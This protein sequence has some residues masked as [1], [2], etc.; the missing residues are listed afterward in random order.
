MLDFLHCPL[1]GPHRFRAV[2]E[3]ALAMA[4]LASAGRAGVDRWTPTGPPG[5]TVQNLVGDPSAPGRVYAVTQSGDLY[6]TRNG[7]RRW[8]PLRDGL[9]AGSV[10]LLT[11]A[12]TRP[13]TVYATVRGGL[14]G[15]DGLY[16]SRDGGATWE[17]RG[18]PPAWYGL[19]VSSADP[20][21]VF[22]AGFPMPYDP[23]VAVYRSADGGVTWHQ[24]LEEVSDSRA[25][26]GLETAPASH[27]VVYLALGEGVIKSSDDGQTWADASELSSAGRLHDLTT[28]AVAPGSP[29]RLYARGESLFR[30]DDGGASWR[31][32]AAQPF[33]HSG[34]L[35]VHPAD[36]DRLFLVSIFEIAESRDGGESWDPLLVKDPRSNGYLADLAIERSSPETFFLATAV[37][38]VYTSRDGGGSWSWTSDGFRDLYARWLAFD[39]GDARVLYLVTPGAEGPEGGSFDW[40]WR[41]GDDGAT[42]SRWLP[43]LDARVAQVV[44]DARWPASVFLATDRGLF[45]ADEAG[46]GVRQLSG[47]GFS[48]LVID[49]HEAHRFFGI[50]DGSVVRSDDAGHTWRETLSFS[51]Y[52]SARQLLFD[53]ARRNRAYALART[54]IVGAEPDTTLYRSD[55]GGSTWRSVADGDELLQL[56]LVPGSP[57]VLYTPLSKSTDGG[58]TWEPTG[59]P[60][61]LFLVVPESPATFYVSRYVQG[62]QELRRS[63]DGGVTWRVLPEPEDSPDDWEQAAVAQ[64]SAPDHLYSYGTGTRA[65]LWQT[66][67]VGS[68]PLIFQE[69]RFE[70][71]AAWRDAE[72]RYGAARPAAVSASGGTFGL[73]GRR[74]LLAA[75][76]VLDCRDV[77]GRFWLAGA[78]ASGLETTVTVTDRVT[79][80]SRN[81]V[82]PR[83]RAATEADTEDVPPLPEPPGWQ[84]D[85]AGSE[86]CTPAALNPPPPE[87][88]SPR[89]APLAPV[90]DPGP[91]EA[92]AESLCLLDGRFRVRVFGV[93]DLGIASPVAAAP[94]PWAAGAFWFYDPEVMDV[95]VEVVDGRSV[96][97]AF[98]VA[99]DGLAADAY[100]VRV[101][102]TATGAVRTYVHPEGPPASE[103]D[104]H[105][106][107]A[108]P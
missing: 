90:E 2:A 92:N 17:R 15:A 67:W 21:V 85:G 24:V 12:P 78:G 106:F 56:A 40:L 18:V 79:G 77:N 76:R 82:F 54:Y 58:E 103:A 22:A 62:G 102:D 36:P 20:D 98:W 108:P 101:V 5:A 59:F 27:G 53:P 25:F 51:G 75:V 96:N 10:S 46:T 1:A 70:A 45:V 41:S 8:I 86:A 63:V 66:R 6:L 60:G 48:E 50:R 11:L 64:P 26:V 28:F 74:R 16:R 73:P 34:R 99:V 4:L 107:Q 32:L 23:T 49:P 81:L 100:Q 83:S 19:A 88:G 13:R 7:G 35:V 87:P 95:A 84:G 68:K 97:G 30:S 91:C 105:A 89:D 52:T 42:W 39:P 3:L 43:G 55:D 38:G 33:E 37:V 71:R 14:S 61:A 65:G 104:F 44:L 47:R 29:G 93:P 69:G 94:E 9:A 80:L 31:E 57:S 72:G